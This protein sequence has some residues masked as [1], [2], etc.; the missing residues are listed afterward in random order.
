MLKAFRFAA[1]RGI[2]AHQP[3]T[4][5]FGKIFL[6]DGSYVDVV[7]GWYDYNDEEIVPAFYI[8]DFEARSSE[9]N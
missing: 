1:Q 6:M 8:S 2:V 4:E 5:A 3:E 7:A 9:S